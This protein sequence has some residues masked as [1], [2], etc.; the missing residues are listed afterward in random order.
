M[1]TL[2]PPYYPSRAHRDAPF[3]SPHLLPAQQG[4]FLLFFILFSFF[5][6]IF[7]PLLCLM[8]QFC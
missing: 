2:L 3:I 8:G 4:L 5:A 6:L 1:M 7:F